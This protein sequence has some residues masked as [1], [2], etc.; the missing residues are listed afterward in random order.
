MSSSYPPTSSPTLYQLSYSQKDL[1]TTPTPSTA[2]QHELYRI[3]A[4]RFLRVLLAL[5]SPN[6]TLSVPSILQ[7]VKSAT[8]IVICLTTVHRCRQ[9]YAYLYRFLACVRN[10]YTDPSLRP[11]H[12]KVPPL[13]A[14]PTLLWRIYTTQRYWEQECVCQR[15][16]LRTRQVE[17]WEPACLIAWFWVEYITWWVVVA[18]YLLILFFLSKW[19]ASIFSGCPRFI[20]PLPTR[21]GVLDRSSQS[22]I[23]HRPSHAPDIPLDVNKP[24]PHEGGRAW[25]LRDYRTQLQPEAKARGLKANTKAVNLASSLTED[26]NRRWG[27]MAVQ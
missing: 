2:L 22:R 7:L 15:Y 11:S 4:M 25:A 16:S 3:S 14:W 23:L 1:F 9:I 5:I 10:L 19:C 27:Q 26:D 12:P 20:P 6:F 17:H 18:L 24:L 21:L 13:M 8:Q